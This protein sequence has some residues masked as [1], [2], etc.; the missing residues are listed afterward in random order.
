[1]KKFSILALL[2]IVALSSCKKDEDED[3]VTP[4]TPPNEEEVITTMEVR[5]TDPASNTVIMTFVDPDGDGGINPTITGGIL[6]ANTVY[7][8]EIQLFNETETPAEII[9]TEILEE[10]DEHQF[11]FDAQLGA[12]TVAYADMDSNGNPLGQMFTLTTG[13]AL[14]GTLTV[15]LRHEPVKEAPGVSDGDITNAGGETDIEVEFDVEIQ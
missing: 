9:T 13:D 11:F 15:T 5:L 14:S 2:F 8:G 7:S 4:P 12:T 6:S 10:A 3:S 1:M